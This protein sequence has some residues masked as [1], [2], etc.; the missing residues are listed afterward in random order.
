MNR[1][2]HL[3]IG[4]LFIGS[5]GL[6]V[7]LTGDS[8]H[9][10]VMNFYR[11]FFAFLTMLL[12]CP[13][14]D[15]KTFKQKKSGIKMYAL[16][17]LL[18]AV[19]FSLTNMAYYY[20]PIQNVI[21]LLSLFPFFVLIF[22]Y[23]LLKE[24][25]TKK[26]IITLIIALIALIII[27]PMRAEGMIGSIFALL[28]SILFGLVVPLMRL[29]E[30]K[31]S[32]GDVMWFFLFA[33]LFLLPFPFIYSFGQITLPVILL[34]VVSTGLGYIFYNFGLE[35][36]EA[37]LS[38]IVLMVVSSVFAIGLALIFLQEQLNPQIIL[39]GS[40]LVASGIYLQH[41]K[42]ALKKVREE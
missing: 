35:K 14:I 11:M 25:I 23:F 37:E 32:I 42:R 3:I 21:F 40:L 7:K 18:I 6:F 39:G 36:V 22:A 30:K 12:I 4:S 29:E 27:N 33:S 28:S 17:G 9:P 24:K 2:S 15:K 5:I 10:M 13:I 26:K 31:H 19:T 20:A 41:H 8:V 1:L 34:G 16:I 38:S